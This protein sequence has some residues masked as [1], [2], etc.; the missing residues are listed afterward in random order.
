M[1]LVI[2]FLLDPIAT[3]A[4]TT[5]IIDELWQKVVQSANSGEIPLSRSLMKKS[6]IPGLR[7]RNFLANYGEHY[8]GLVAGVETTKFEQGPAIINELRDVV[9]DAERL[10]LGAD[11]VVE[12]FNE[13][14]LVGYW[15]EQEMKRHTDGEDEVESPITTL[16]LGSNAHMDW[17]YNMSTYRHQEKRQ[18]GLVLKDGA[19][20]PG[21]LNYDLYNGLLSENL[22]PEEFNRRYKDLVE[23]NCKRLGQR[24]Y[25]TANLIHGSLVMM[26]GTAIS[27][28]FE[29]CICAFSDIPTFH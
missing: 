18:Q 3:D 15:T 24:S 8:H 9:T 26:V 16:S 23:Q 19:P 25:L 14:L 5:D 28:Y 27:D 20:L 10:A 12:A 17:F 1:E 13:L 6:G 29:V 11:E 21:T 7:T 2:F 22:D 4:E